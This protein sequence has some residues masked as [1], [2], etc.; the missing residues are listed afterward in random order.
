MIEYDSEKKTLDIKVLAVPRASKTEIKGEHDGFLRIRLAAP[1][2]KGAANDELVAF[3]AKLLNLPK[4]A[5][6]IASGGASRRK[7]VR[8]SG[9]DEAKALEITS[10][11]S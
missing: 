8:V 2:V 7:T 11:L 3:F 5:V 9:I 4:S 6:E 1:P 10:R